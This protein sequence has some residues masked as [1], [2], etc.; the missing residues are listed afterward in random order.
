[1]YKVLGAENCSGEDTQ[2]PVP[3]AIQKPSIK[4]PSINPP[5]E[6]LTSSF[7]ESF[8]S[9]GK[10]GGGA[11][12]LQEGHDIVTRE[13]CAPTSLNLNNLGKAAV[14][15]FALFCGWG[16]ADLRLA[17]IEHSCAYSSSQGFS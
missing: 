5:P 4:K 8:I 6:N 11:T 16:H 7:R 15:H 3:V 2:Q 12:V 13:T 9:S 1:M 14:L 10:Q 17:T